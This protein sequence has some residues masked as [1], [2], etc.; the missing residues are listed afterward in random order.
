MLHLQIDIAEI[1]GFSAGASSASTSLSTIR[2][3]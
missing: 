1:V 2:S 3:A